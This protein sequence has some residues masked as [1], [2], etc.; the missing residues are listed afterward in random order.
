MAGAT[1]DGRKD[2]AGSIVTSETGFAHTGTIVNDKGGYV[3][4][5]HL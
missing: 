1:D 3:F 2:S 5:T 4:V